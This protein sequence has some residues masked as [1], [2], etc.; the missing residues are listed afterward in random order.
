MN[1]RLKYIIN[2]ILYLLFAALLILIKEMD[3]LYLIL[4][5]VLILIPNVLFSI[6]YYK[7]HPLQHLNERN[8]T[9]LLFCSMPLYFL[10]LLTMFFLIIFFTTDPFAYKYKNPLAIIFVE[11]TWNISII[12]MYYIFKDRFIDNEIKRDGKF[13]TV[14]YGFMFFMGSIAF[15]LLLLYYYS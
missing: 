8:K 14:L 9:R 2:L 7:K 13:S 4:F 15:S 3:I 6:L 1:E 11:C 5:I 12:S 10:L